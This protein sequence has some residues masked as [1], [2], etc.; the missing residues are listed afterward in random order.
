MNATVLSPDPTRC[1]DCRAVLTRPGAC[2]ACGLTLAGPP[3]ARLWEIDTEL[4]RLDATRST[5]Q[6]ERARRP[7]SDSVKTTC[8]LARTERLLAREYHGRF[9]IE[10]LQKAADA[11]RR[12]AP[13]GARSPVEVLVDPDGPALVAANR[14]RAGELDKE[15]RR[16]AEGHSLPFDRPMHYI[17]LQ[18]LCSQHPVSTLRANVPSWASSRPCRTT[19]ASS[20]VMS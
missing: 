9:F 1:P 15:P 2:G 17:E 19:W 13:P 3:A 20:R 8:S 11:W 7:T 18:L 16:D 5:L 12:V 14:L 6:A 4:L 10:L